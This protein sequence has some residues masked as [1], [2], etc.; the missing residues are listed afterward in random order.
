MRSYGRALRAGAE[1]LAAVAAATGLVAAL[2]PIAP[3]AGLGVLYLLAVLGLAIRR[4]QL[5]ALGTAALSVLAL[6]YF[7]LEPRHQLTISNS[8]NVAALVV[9]AIVAVVVGRLASHARARTAQAEERAREAEIREREAEMVAGA[10]SAVLEGAGVDAQLRN[11]ERS[12]RR[13]APGAGARIE[14]NPV[15][16]RRDDEVAVRL[17]ARRRS[18]WLYVARDAGWGDAELRRVADALGRLVDVVLERADVAGHAAEAD[19]T[20][21]ADV[22]K[23][24]VLH[25][26]SHDLRSP[27]TAI[28]TAVGGLA[29]GGLGPEDRAEL[30]AVLES[31]TARLAGLVDDLLDVSRIQAGAVNPRADWCDLGEAVAAAA[32]QVRAAGSSHSIELELP[33]DLP[34]VRA[35]HVQVE[36][37]FVNLL[38]NAVRHSPPDAPVRVTGGVGGGRVTVRVIDRGRGVLAADRARIF[39]PFEGG[40]ASARGSG[41]G[42]AIARGFV[43]ANG[44]R[45]AL[46][47]G[48]S[49]DTSF[50]VSFP[51]VAQPAAAT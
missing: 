44:G 5:A 16:S 11:V 1:A 24:A 38:D 19:A 20:R 18:G 41:L 6:N 32:A 27:L 25:A 8:Q 30:I 50:A 47:S 13:A 43:E 21:R 12:L 14:L 4:G 15:P 35:D 33:P 36:R 17:G 10:A 7:F 9:F 31:E 29:N 46:Q 2:D 34:L 22:A 28:V 37:V 45:I 42:L 39:E 40:G 3:I 23:T 51:L 26:I 49:E 48:V